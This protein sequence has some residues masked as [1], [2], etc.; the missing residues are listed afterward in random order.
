MPR[1]QSFFERLTGSIRMQSDSVDTFI[2]NERDD[3][4]DDYAEETSLDS[5]SE[6]LGGELSVDVYQTDK[7]IIVKCMTAGV[8]KGDLD[9]AITREQ[10][11]IRG[12]RQEDRLIADDQYYHKELYWGSF[13]RV[14]QLP[15][16][17]EVEECF[18]EE[19]HGL[20]TITL[21]LLD[22]YKEARLKVR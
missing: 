7:A 2:D 22:K 11:T 15:E 16:E 20:L 5:S 10:L 6:E 19:E 18:A 3:Y 14:I 21:P 12:S 9:I 8:K 17:V 1:K 13:Y 4:A